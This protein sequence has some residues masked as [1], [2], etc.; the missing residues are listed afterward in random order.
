MTSPRRLDWR[1]LGIALLAALVALGAYL[2]ASLRLGGMGFP[3]DDAWIHQTYARNLVQLGQWA[4]VPNQ[5][6]AGSTSP[7]WAVLQSP[8]ILLGISPWMWS[9]FLGLVSLALT[10]CMAGLWVARGMGGPG[11]WFWV[12]VVGLGFEWHLVWAALSGMETLLLGGAALALLWGMQKQPQRSLLWGAL[13][14]LMV[15]IRPDGL[16]L[17]LAYAWLILFGQ[18]GVRTSAARLGGFAVGAC[19]LILPYLGFNYALAGQIWPNTFYAKQAEYAVLR[20]APLLARLGGEFLQP[21]VG[22][23]VLLLPGLLLW[24]F[25]KARSRRWA[26]FAP[27]VW[28]S[29]YL[30][31]YALRL[32]VTYQH[33]RYAM[34]TIPVWITLG[35]LGTLGWVDLGSQSSWRRIIS[36]G[37]LVSWL[38]VT[39]AFWLVGARAFAR[40][41]AVINSEMV[42]T[43]LWVRAHTDSK[44]VIAA[45]DIG[46]LGYFGCRP[47][48]DLA[49]LVNPEVIPFIRDEQRLGAYLDARGADYLMTFPDWYPSL[50]AGKVPVYQ[51]HAPFSPSQGGE[52]MAV[53]TWP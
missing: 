38:V 4:F 30:A 3:L 37:W 48:L 46:A 18:A 35:L 33:G 7:L 22:P 23:G 13:V 15:W 40:D 8:G 31:A 1:R 29:A 32:P 5:P 53:Y 47:I 12:G 49:G 51:T 27:L 34:P 24:I 28:A 42:Q 52:N 20:Q 25:S 6:S 2:L 10:A 39:G 16:T 21:L 50:T 19:L 45:H 11:R 41:V 9:A 43:S 36:R 44:E 17:G 14:G 26:D